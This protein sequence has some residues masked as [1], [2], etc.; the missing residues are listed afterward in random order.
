[1]NNTYI[2]S[3]NITSLDDYAVML[4]V[5]LLSIASLKQVHVHCVKIGILNTEMTDRVHT[6][7]FDLQRLIDSYTQQSDA[8]LALLPAGVNLADTITRLQA[9]IAEL[10]KLKTKKKKNDIKN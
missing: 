10:K 4:A 9:D 7:M 1:M 5:G 6:M 8:V 3:D 2:N